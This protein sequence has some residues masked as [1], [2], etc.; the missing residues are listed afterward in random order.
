LVF[1]KYSGLLFSRW[2]PPFHK[3]EQSLGVVIYGG[4]ALGYQTVTI[5]HQGLDAHV[6]QR[7][8]SITATADAGAVAQRRCRKNPYP[9]TI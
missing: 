6:A 7:S 4:G 1:S 8:K 2:F 5:D 3:S 9:V